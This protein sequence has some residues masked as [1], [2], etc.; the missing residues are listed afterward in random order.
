VFA[1]FPQIIF[2]I[3]R[4]A[5]G[6]GGEFG[7]PSA[8][9]SALSTFVFNK[10]QIKIAVSH[11]TK[12]VMLFAGVSDENLFVIPN[13]ADPSRFLPN[14]NSEHLKKKL[15]LSGKP[16]LLTVG[17]MCE[18]K[19]QEIVI[20]ALAELKKDFPNLIYL[21]VGHP[22]DKVKLETLANHFRVS[23][24]VYFFPNVPYA[25][26]PLYY[27]MADIYILNSRISKD[28]DFEGFGISILEAA[29]SGIP[30]IGSKGFGIDDAIE[31]EKTGLLIKPNSISATKEA[32]SNLLKNKA[33][34]KR[35]GTNAYH[36]ALNHFSWSQIALFYHDKIH[37]LTK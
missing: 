20:Q 1:F 9:H 32:I 13:G 10:A 6:H 36:R 2:K 33:L 17:R 15:N 21:V 34:C 11:Y 19:G 14:Q 7:F 23:E 25:E 29:L 31:H 3:P 12:K 4:I 24:S 26:L 18:R 16:V 35:M 5:I 8:F 37:L 30:S 28:G 22:Q 27:S